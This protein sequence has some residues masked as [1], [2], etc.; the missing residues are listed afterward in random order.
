MGKLS[1]DVAKILCAKPSG[2]K[3]RSAETETGGV[4]GFAGFVGNGVFVGNNSDFFEGEGGVFTGPTPRTQ[5][6][7]NQMLVG[8]T[9]DNVKAEFDEF[10]SKSLSVFDNLVGVSF[11]LRLHG[12]VQGDADAGDR[13]IKGTALESG[14]NRK[15]YFFGNLLS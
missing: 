15:I 12:L 5:V 8:P 6:N 9:G 7:E 10:R 4:P 13:V 1:G 11:E 14:K 2:R 3:E